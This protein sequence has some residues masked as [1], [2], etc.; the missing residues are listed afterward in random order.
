LFAVLAVVAFAIAFILHTVAHNDA[1]I[2]TD[3]E[4]LGFLFIAA[5]LAW[6]MGIALAPWRRQPPG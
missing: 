3:A 1:R 6:G 2:V 4:I 5:H